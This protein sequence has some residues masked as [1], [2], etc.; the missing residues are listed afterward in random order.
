MKPKNF[1]HNP[2][3]GN[4]GLAG[5]DT[6]RGPIG[7]W[8]AF[9]VAAVLLFLVALIHAVPEMRQELFYNMP[10]AAWAAVQSFATSTMSALY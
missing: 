6:V 3:P 5:L 9:V 2:R 7:W 10:A 4:T 1:G 8:A